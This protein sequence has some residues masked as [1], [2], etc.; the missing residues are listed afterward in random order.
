[1]NIKGN[2]AWQVLVVDD[3]PTVR[4]AVKM[5]LEHDGHRVETV[6]SAAAA[7][8]VLE[9]RQF[10]LIITDFSMPGMKGDQL[11]ARIKQ[12]RPDQPII[13]ATAFVDEFKTFGRPDGG[14][15]FL[16][17]K[18]F[19]LNDLREAVDQVL[20]G[21]IPVSDGSLSIVA[22]PTPPKNF[23]PPPKS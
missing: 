2:S 18:P 3:E 4:K 19:S 12:R 13:M 20:A 16:L 10:D 1:M 9:H 15:D 11:V 7:L 17:N 14:V 8:A 22:K 6:D 21:K 5:L 23:I